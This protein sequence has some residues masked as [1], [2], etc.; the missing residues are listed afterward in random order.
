MGLSRR[1]RSLVIATISTFVFLVLLQ[2][3]A[4]NT[5]FRLTDTAQLSPYI[6]KS[7]WWTSE[8]NSEPT[9]AYAQYATDG[10][11]FCNAVSFIEWLK[12]GL[13]LNT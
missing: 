10:T 9:F 2:L 11:Y 3:V 8:T 1:V 7:I 12:D 4:T 5:S 6:P 13:V